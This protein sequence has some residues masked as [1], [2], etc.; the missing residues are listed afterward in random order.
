M[1]TALVIIRVNFPASEAGYDDVS[2]PEEDLISQG[3]DVAELVNRT[4]AELGPVIRD[5]GS[6]QTVPGIH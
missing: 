5:A 6:L 4:Q 1:S 3:E 2:E